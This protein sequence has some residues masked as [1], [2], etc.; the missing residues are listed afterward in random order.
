MFLSVS[1]CLTGYVFII[2][3]VSEVNFVKVNI[4]LTL[5]M[6]RRGSVYV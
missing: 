4:L 2:S 5:F 1:I 6:Q 3:L